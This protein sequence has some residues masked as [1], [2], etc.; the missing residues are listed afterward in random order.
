MIDAKLIEQY[1]PYAKSSLR[2]KS[3]TIYDA[4]ISSLI[5][6]ALDDLERLGLITDCDEKNRTAVNAFVKAMFGDRIT[7]GV[8]WL[9]VWNK[10]LRNLE[11]DSS[12][13]YDC[14]LEDDDGV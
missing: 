4:E 14:Y 12:R 6:S 1:L 8:M 7:N 11:S 10:L 2:I 3:T 13:H 5:G 9:E